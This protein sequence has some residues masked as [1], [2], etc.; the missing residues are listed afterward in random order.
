[1]TISKELHDELLKGCEPPEDRPGD[2]GLMQE[3]KIRRTER[4]LG[5]ELTSHLGYEDGKEAPTEPT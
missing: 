4:M 5:A 2:T 3:L 1:M